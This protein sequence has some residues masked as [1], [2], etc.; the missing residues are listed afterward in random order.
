MF[1]FLHTLLLYTQTQYILFFIILFTY[2]FLFAPQSQRNRN[3][4]IHLFFIFF[5]NEPFIRLCR[6]MNVLWHIARRASRHR[7]SRRRRRQYQL[8]VCVWTKYY[9]YYYYN[10][11]VLLIRFVCLFLD[12]KL[13][14]CARKHYNTRT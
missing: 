12:T 13:H 11:N 8:Q 1:V 10:K 4:F 2:F 5:I 9:Y 3:S 6:H 14:A 7:D